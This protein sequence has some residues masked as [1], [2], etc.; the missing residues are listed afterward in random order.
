MTQEFFFAP[1]PTIVFLMR[2]D[3]RYLIA[4]FR[5]GASSQSAADDDRGAS[6]LCAAEAE[7]R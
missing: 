4:H 2:W 5:E 3:M 6:S 1:P 7:G